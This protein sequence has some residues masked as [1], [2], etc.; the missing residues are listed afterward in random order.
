MSGH[1]APL[2]LRCFWYLSDNAK[3][4]FPTSHI[5]ASDCDRSIDHRRSHMLKLHLVWGV[6]PRWSPFNRL[7]VCVCVCVPDIVAACSLRL[8]HPPP[9]RHHTHTHTPTPRPSLSRSHTITGKVWA[10]L[11]KHWRPKR[12]NSNTLH[13]TAQLMPAIIPVGGDRGRGDARCFI[14]MVCPDKA[15]FSLQHLSVSWERMGR[16]SQCVE[17]HPVIKT[18]Q[19]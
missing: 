7:S 11:H 8:L 16:K 17:Y 13:N 3:P 15:P 4:F 12:E 1:W 14:P 19:N 18:F 9:P 5:R 6:S 2:I 10:S